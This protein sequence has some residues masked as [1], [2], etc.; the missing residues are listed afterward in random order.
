MNKKKEEKI[1][2]GKHAYLTNIMIGLGLGWGNIPNI[3]IRSITFICKHIF[4]IYVHI[5]YVY[6]FFSDSN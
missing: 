5:F 2:I 1:Y 6:I 3:N 4:Q